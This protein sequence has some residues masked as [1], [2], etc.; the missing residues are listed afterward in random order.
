MTLM[1]LSVAGCSGSLPGP[2]GP[3]SCYLVDVGGARVVL[4]VGSGALG[5]LQRMTRLDAIDAVFLSH[6][7]PDHCMDLCG[8]YVWARYAPA[9]M[10]SPPP[11][12]RVLAPKGARERMA[13]A[14]GDATPQ[15]L[16]LVFDFTELEDGASYSIGE[17]QITVA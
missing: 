10:A 3:A 2:T 1:R 11:R 14:Y 15:D 7:H 4:D 9:N 16:D 5:P 8:W 17:T 13:R 6:L 12:L